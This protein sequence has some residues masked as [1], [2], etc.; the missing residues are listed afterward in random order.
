MNLLCAILLK[1]NILDSNKWNANSF[2]YCATG[3]YFLS[4]YTI[5]EICFSSE[6]YIHLFF[7]VFIVFSLN[8]INVDS[9]VFSCLLFTF[10]DYGKET[11]CKLLNRKYWFYCFCL[12]R[13]SFN[14]DHKKKSLVDVDQLKMK[15]KYRV[16]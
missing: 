1:N 8:H 13:F 9:R 7:S 5:W 11:L 10:H 6:R 4:K 12:F 14:I 3:V 16:I 2:F 15:K